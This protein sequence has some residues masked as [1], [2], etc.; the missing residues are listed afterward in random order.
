M[1]SSTRRTYNRT[2]QT[3][4]NWVN[5]NS[6]D[7]GQYGPTRIVWTE[8]GLT[9]VTVYKNLLSPMV[10]KEGTPA[11][12]IVFKCGPRDFSLCLTAHRE[13]EI[14]AMQETF[15]AAVAEALPLCRVNDEFAR[16]E[17]DDGRGSYVRNY[18]GVPRVN[19][20]KWRQP[21]HLARLQGG[22]EGV[23]GVDSGAP[24]VR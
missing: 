8:L 19:R 7:S 20:L 2:R 14:L 10:I 21:E 13:D 18:R 12:T 4:P 22:S 17:E 3:Q 23:P 11:V 5:P 24:E 15:N 16:K 1:A 6:P 9:N